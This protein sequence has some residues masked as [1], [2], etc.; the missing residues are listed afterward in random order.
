MEVKKALDRVNSKRNGGGGSSDAVAT[1]GSGNQ[2]MNDYQTG[3][4]TN[5]D[6]GNI[7][8]VI[9][10]NQNVVGN[11]Q[12]GIGYRWI[13]GGKFYMLRQRGRRHF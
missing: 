5:N 1:F 10:N 13:A 6:W 9:G 8:N 3:R 4:V 7:R 12:N 11:N 2:G